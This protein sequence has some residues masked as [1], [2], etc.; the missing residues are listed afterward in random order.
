MKIPI[1]CP[2]WTKKGKKL[3]SMCRKALFDF[4]LL[5]NVKRLALALSG[6][7][8]SLSLLF[9][10]KAIL[11][12]GF[13]N[14]PLKAIHISG[15]FSCGA[16]V[17]ESFLKEICAL[18]KVPLIIKKISQ[19]SK[20]LSCYNCS[21]RRRTLI[22][23][24]AKKENF[25]TVAFGHHRDDN[26]QTLLLNLLHKAE[27]APN[28][29][30]ITLYDYGVTII[31]P[32]IYIPEKEIL[33]FAKLYGFARITC[34][35]PVGNHSKRKEVKKLLMQME[36]IFPNAMTNL[37]QAAHMYGSKKALHSLGYSCKKSLP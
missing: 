37:A 11:G 15:T 27:F 23:E 7:K 14:I 22:F 32:L 2:P 9:L 35:C 30:K 8:D 16:A 36:E 3:E 6:G 4:S 33:N 21:R 28:M 13:P 10:L 20:E 31:R 34:Q 17:H 19:N 18:L 12:Q 25:N 24:A 29:P 1:A 26:I 5:N